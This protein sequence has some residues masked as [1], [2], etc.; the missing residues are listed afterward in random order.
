MPN[1]DL[2]QPAPYVPFDDAAAVFDCTPFA[3]VVPERE[4]V[5]TIN[6]A[7]IN[8]YRW[9]GAEWDNFDVIGVP[10]SWEG[11]YRKDMCPPTS[12][13]SHTRALQAM[14]VVN[15][16]EAAV[17]RYL[18]PVQVTFNMPGCLPEA[19]PVYFAD[20]DEAREYVLAEWEAVAGDCPEWL[21]ETG[22]E[23][24]AWSDAVEAIGRM[25]IG[26]HADDPQP[27][28]AYRWCI[29]ERQVT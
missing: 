17:Q 2:Y 3:Y 22:M 20:V 8:L 13:N 26:S 23:T 7:Y 9:T 4:I 18:D 5:A 29:E 27:G 19:E 15:Y 24:P 12:G 16:L 25:D 21:D 11:L 10:Q 1:P 14:E 28:S 6:G